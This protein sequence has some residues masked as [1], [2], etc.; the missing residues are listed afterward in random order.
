MFP[1]SENRRCE[2]QGF[3]YRLFDLFL[4]LLDDVATHGRGE[5]KQIVL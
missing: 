1:E 5:R 4:R 3:T 2:E